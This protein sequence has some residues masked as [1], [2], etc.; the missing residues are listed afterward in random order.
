MV[1]EYEV[2]AAGGDITPGSLTATKTDIINPPDTAEVLDLF[3]GTDLR[4]DAAH[5]G[6]AGRNVNCKL[7]RDVNGTG[8]DPNHTGA[9]Q[10][11]NIMLTYTKSTS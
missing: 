8:P 6:G 5:L 2:V 4:I 10:L 9:F 1:L 11:L 7:F 3:T